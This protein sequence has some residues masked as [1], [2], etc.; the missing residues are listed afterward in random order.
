MLLVVLGRDS[1]LGRPY[2]IRNELN[3]SV[4]G[5]VVQCMG[6]TMPSHFLPFLLGAAGVAR[7]ESAQH[8]ER[9]RIEASV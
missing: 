3:V 7:H 6:R 8:R 1:A 9:Y 4:D 5:G 2:P